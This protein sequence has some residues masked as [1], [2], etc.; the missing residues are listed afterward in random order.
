M[1]NLPAKPSQN[2]PRSSRTDIVFAFALAICLYLA[3]LVHEVL[4]IVYVSALFAVVLLPVVNGIRKLRIRGW[5]PN[6]VVAI[7]MLFLIVATLAALF[8]SIAL[9]PVARD[10]S[11]FAHELPVRGPQFLL[12]LQQFPIVRQ[13][14]LSALSAKLQDLASTS[15][16]YVVG[17]ITTGAGK[18]FN[19]LTGVILTVYFMLEGEH[20]Y[21]WFLS[22]VPEGQRDRLDRALGRAE[23][24]MGKWL[25]GQGLLML[26]LGLV[27]TIT[28]LALKV[29]YA[30]ALGV[31]MG[32]FNLI[33]IVGALVSVSLALIVAAIDSWGRALGVLIVYLIYAQVE[34]SVLTPRIMKSSVGLSGLAVLIALLLGASVA[35]VVGALVSVPT[36]VL[37]AE[38]LEEYLVKPKVVATDPAETEHAPA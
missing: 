21:A 15:A 16:S 33:P 9:P 27:S 14:D 17:F 38:L 36:A 28:F 32:A 31:L 10:L 5:Q 11:Q 18:F 25:L 2:K 8:F 22:I 34:N 23:I 12:R 6:R 20:A 26:I 19:L 24:R 1:N 7:L 4:L 35:G 30:Y 37:V 29:R 3:W 13:V